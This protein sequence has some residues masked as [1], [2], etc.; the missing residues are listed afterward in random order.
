MAIGLGRRQFI[1]AVGGVAGAWSFAAR[2]Q[3]A[4][5][6]IGFLSSRSPGES[7]D[8]IAAFRQ[9]LKEAGFIERQN[10]VIDFRWAEG[11]YDRLPELATD[12]VHRRVS[13]IAA[14]SPQAALAAKVATTTIPIVFQSGADPV[15][16]GLVSSLNRPGGN[17][18]G[19]YRAAS[20]FVPKC[21][22]L[23]R[24]VSPKATVVAVLINPTSVLRDLQSRDAQ[25]AAL[26]L[27]LQLHVLNAS[28]E[29]DFEPVFKS[30]TDQK[31][32][33]LVIGTDSFFTS[34]SEQLASMA[35]RY[36]VP[37]I[38][39]SREFATA[40]GLMS[41]DAS[42]ADQYRQVGGY[43]GRILKGEKPADLPVQQATK[44]E[45]VINLKTAKTLGLAIP[46]KLIAIA[47][48]VIE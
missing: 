31:V 5:Q 33:A 3:P 16:A 15:T 8:A 20:E 11:A 42:L 28:N 24:E 26:D 23:L 29:H 2:A 44:Y 47:D 27:G 6:E 48:E 43:I 45:L 39:T 38:A 25:A 9:G 32:G 14:I 17:L 19:F 18:T 13:V 34:R 22:E 10:V 1:F 36:L 37:A 40:G 7:A 35:A 12:L 46:D 4:M 30:L 41:Y 21:M